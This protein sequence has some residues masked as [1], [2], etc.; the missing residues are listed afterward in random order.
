MGYGFGYGSPWS[1]AVLVPC[2]AEPSPF[3]L[4]SSVGTS[5]SDR[6]LVNIVY[7]IE[8]GASSSSS[9]GRHGSSQQH[10][11]IRIICC[12]WVLGGPGAL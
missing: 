6:A 11:Q 12:A 10:Y 8:K 9:S 2:P 4:K 1:L 5:A 3:V 7:N